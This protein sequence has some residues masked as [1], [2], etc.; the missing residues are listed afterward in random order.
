[1]ELEGYLEGSPVTGDA[2]VMDGP[3]R[4]LQ[5]SQGKNPVGILTVFDGNNSVN[6]GMHKNVR[7]ATEITYGE[8]TVNPA[9]PPPC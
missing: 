1:M 4:A 6:Y 9:N 3:Q 8:H 2:A 7:T 5:P